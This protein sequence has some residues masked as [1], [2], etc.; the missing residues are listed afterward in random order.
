MFPLFLAIFLALLL[1]GIVWAFAT[2]IGPRRPSR[3][4]LRSY[5]CGIRPSEPVHRRLDIQF[6]RVGILFLIFGVELAFFY[7]WALALV[8][9]ENPARRLIAFLDMVFFGGLFLAGFIYAWAKGGFEWW[10][11]GGRDD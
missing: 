6:Y 11:P 2:Y 3:E 5:E 4:K 7:P 10:R 1:S 9:S 8:N